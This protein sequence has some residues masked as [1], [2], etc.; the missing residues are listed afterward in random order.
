MVLALVGIAILW[1]EC[2][3]VANKE[4]TDGR[5]SHVDNRGFSDQW[6]WWCTRFIGEC[7]VPLFKAI[8]VVKRVCIFTYT[9][10]YMYMCLCVQGVLAPMYFHES[11][12]GLSM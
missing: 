4:R 6:Q 8:I 10:L 5:A 1:P 11:M 2:G 9:Y 7:F 3:R 12:S